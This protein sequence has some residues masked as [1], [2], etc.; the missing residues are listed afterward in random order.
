[1]CIVSILNAVQYTEHRDDG[2]KDAAVKAPIETWGQRLSDTLR[3]ALAAGDFA[4]A[5]RLAEVGDGQTR[6]LAKEYTFMFR[7][8]GITIRVLLRLLG[9]TAARDGATEPAA[10]ATDLAALLR[11]FRHDLAGSDRLSGSAI[12]ATE[13]P[14]ALADEIVRTVEALDAS[15]AQFEMDQARRADEIVR[16]IEMADRAQALRLVD[17]KE[18]EAYLPRHDRLIRFMADSFA[19]VLRHYG[20]DELL[21]FHL[22]AAEA[23][24]SGF[25]KWENMSAAEFAWTSA[26]LLKQHM[27]QVT[28]REED[29]RYTIEQRPCGSGGR[30]RLSGAYAGADALPFVESPGPLTFG[31]ARLPVYCSHCAIWNGVATLHWFGRA[32]WVFENASRPNGACTLHIYKRRDGTPPDY[33]RRLGMAPNGSDA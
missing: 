15:E 19:W 25:E 31:E 16:A 1:L 17:A 32:H 2:K 5:K 11:R 3:A 14:L 18:Q 23:Q 10:A 28:V 20:P 6:N 27:G 24:R 12:A 4:L 21:H 22:A 9:E 8:L 29:E 26:F 33:V 30:L 13:P 7:G